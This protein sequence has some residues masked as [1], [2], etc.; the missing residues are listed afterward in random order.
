MKKNLLKKTFQ[1]GLMDFEIIILVLGV[2][3]FMFF[4]SLNNVLATPDGFSD[5]N[6][7]ANETRGPT[8]NYSLNTSGG[9]ITTLNITATVKDIR[10]KA[11]VGWISGKFALS[12]QTGA[13]I[14][15][16]SAATVSGEVYA[17]RNASLVS[18][19]QIKCAN[20]SM[21]TAENL[22][23]NHTSPDDNITRTFNDTTHN[24]FYVGNVSIGNG[25]CYS[26]NTYVNNATQ[27]NRFEEIA[28]FDGLNQTSGGNL[29][30]ATILENKVIG[31]DS[32]AYDFQMIV[33]ENGAASF[34]GA[35]AYYLYVELT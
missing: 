10:W 2:F 16:W 28:L 15:D 26:L 33:P 30:Y 7:T 29:V 4:S 19:S 32:V 27:N 24:A 23:M 5:V 34:N 12:D 14:Y 31:F 1:K 11:F 6:I 3:F 18:W 35:T 25:T 22:V 20:I 8:T 9:F 17:T 21:F 13:T